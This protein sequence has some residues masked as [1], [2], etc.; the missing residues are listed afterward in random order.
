MNYVVIDLEMC[1]VPNSKIKRDYRWDMETI[2]IG[3]VLVNKDYEIVDKFNS[4]VKPQEGNINSFIRHLTGISRYLVKNAP[5]FAE[6]IESFKEW[7]PKD[8]EMRF[9]SW[10][11]TDRKQLIEESG[12]KKVDLGAMGDTFEDW[13]DAQS[14]FGEKIDSEKSYKLEDALFLSDVYPEGNTHDGLDDAYNT[15]RLF[16]KMETEPEFELN[17]MYIEAKKE[18]VEH[19]SFAMG[20]LFAGLQV[21]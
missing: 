13:I 16:V 17:E 7:L 18:D 8:E 12:Y 3:A 1:Y 6:V 20:D 10:S 5:S 4:Y 11:M 9:V 21:G 15:A 19:L 14:L 2:Q